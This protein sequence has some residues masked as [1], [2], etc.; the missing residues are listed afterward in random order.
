MHSFFF[1]SYNSQPQNT[2]ETT[3]GQGEE[4]LF[5]LRLN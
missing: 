2:I 1:K 3:M 5:A 4:V